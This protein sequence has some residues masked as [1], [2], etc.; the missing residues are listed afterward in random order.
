VMIGYKFSMYVMNFSEISDSELSNWLH[1][2][3]K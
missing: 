1:N 3:S 2:D